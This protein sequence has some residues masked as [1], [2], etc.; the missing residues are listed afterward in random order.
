[1]RKL[2]FLLL[3]LAASAAG[4]AERFSGTANLA[5]SKTAVDAA[6]SSRLAHLELENTALRQELTAINAAAK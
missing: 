2:C 5:A 6:Q 1:M 4:F 3:F